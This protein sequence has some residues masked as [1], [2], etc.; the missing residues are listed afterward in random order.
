ML[1]IVQLQALTSE[2]SATAGA[3]VSVSGL[4]TS[5]WTVKIQVA[6]FTGSSNTARLIVEDSEDGFSSDILAGP[7][8]SLQSSET[9]SNDVIFSFTSYAWP[10]L[11]IGGGSATLRI[12]LTNIT[13]GTITYSAWV[14]YPS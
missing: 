9:S 3:G 4:P 11:R 12:H 14:E 13:G 5:G 1:N 8:V 2:T 10:D 7:G 6:S